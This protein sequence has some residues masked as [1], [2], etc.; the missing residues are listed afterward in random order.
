[1]IF[2]G[3]LVLEDQGTRS[4]IILPIDIFFRSLARDIEKNAIGIILS[5]TGSDGTLGTRAIKEAGGMVMAQDERTAKFDGMPRSSISTGLVDYI[6]PPHEM[7]EALC[8]ADLVVSRAGLSI[9][10]E[11]SI[12]GKPTVLIPLY[13]T[14]QE[15]NAAY[16]QK[17]NAVVAVSEPSLNAKMFAN[18]LRDLLSNKDRLNTLSD[19]IK[20]IM[21]TDGAKHVTDLLLSIAKR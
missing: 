9:L 18:L 15:F 11:L 12:G 2:H 6:L 21:P 17:H 10:T 5:G 1:M 16:Y 7:P 3:K 20:K 13:K 8:T 14:H 19:N 4:G